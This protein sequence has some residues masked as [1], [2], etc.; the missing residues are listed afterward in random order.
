MTAILNKLVSACQTIEANAGS[1][2]DGQVDTSNFAT[3][4]E[5]TQKADADHT[6]YSFDSIKIGEGTSL[7]DNSWRLKNDNGG[8]VSIR[9]SVS[10][11]AYG[12]HRLSLDIDGGELD[13]DNNSSNARCKITPESIWFGNSSSPYINPIMSI[14]KTEIS[15]IE[16]SGNTDYVVWKS[17][18]DALEARVAALEAK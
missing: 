15:K 18:L 4:E 11:F 5:L 2:G 13:F 7:F 8:G 14:T 1:G 12:D 16:E 17:Q 9:A 10:S 6:H 3:K